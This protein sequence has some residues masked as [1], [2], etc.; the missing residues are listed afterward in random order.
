MDR[1]RNYNL[2]SQRFVTGYDNIPFIQTNYKGDIKYNVS[3]EVFNTDYIKSYFKI[4]NLSNLYAIYIVDEG[5]D[6]C[7][8]NLNVISRYNYY[9]KDIILVKA[10]LN[11]FIN[12]E[13]NNRAELSRPF[14]FNT[15][16]FGKLNLEEIL[17]TCLY[18]KEIII[19]SFIKNIVKLDP[20]KLL[21]DT[22]IR[23]VMKF[24]VDLSEAFIED[25]LNLKDNTLDINDDYISKVVISP[26]CEVS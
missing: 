21:N 15:D 25:V 12:I 16:S 6:S 9:G 1:L 13:Y 23:N 17:T 3:V 10:E 22:K 2:I 4:F 14:F 5:D 8:F 18:E 19:G 26:L 24:Y 20:L 11:F 7:Y